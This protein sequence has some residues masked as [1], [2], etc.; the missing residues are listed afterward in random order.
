[1]KNQTM[2]IHHGEEHDQ[3]QGA[4]V[5]PIYQNSLFVFEDWDDIDQA[6]DDPTDN[7]IY[8]RGKNPGV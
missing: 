4:V 1:M 8:T 6:F 3:Y 5:P 2:L 7:A